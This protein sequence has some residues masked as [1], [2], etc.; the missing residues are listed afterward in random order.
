M[1][2]HHHGVNAHGRCRLLTSAAKEFGLPRFQ[3]SSERPF[4]PGQEL[5]PHL[6]RTHLL[7]LPVWPHGN[8]WWKNCRK[9]YRFQRSEYHVS[10]LNCLSFIRAAAS[11]AQWAANITATVL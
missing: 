6:A 9:G 7:I 3:L 8:I 10:C 4:W 11:R 1:H 5:H 2:V